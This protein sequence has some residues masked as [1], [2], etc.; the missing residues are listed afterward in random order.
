ML[1]IAGRLHVPP[2]HRDAYLAAAQDATRQARSAPGCL[3][4]VQAPDPLEP[5]VVVVYER[6][7]SEQALLAFRTSDPDAPELPPLAGAD[8]RRYEVLSAGDA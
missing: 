7:D 8:V 1:I 3:E 4:F 2:G 6:W 5:D